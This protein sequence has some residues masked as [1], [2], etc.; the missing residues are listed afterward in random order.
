MLESAQA[1]KFC[2]GNTHRTDIDVVGIANQWEI[3]SACFMSSIPKAAPQPTKGLASHL[4]KYLEWTRCQI[5][6]QH[7]D[8]LLANDT[9][10]QRLMCDILHCERFLRDFAD[11]CPEDDLSVAVGRNLMA[12]L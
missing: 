10:G 4:R 8:A 9:D 12:I 1:S 11:S 2:E 3:T 7:L 5:D 6:S